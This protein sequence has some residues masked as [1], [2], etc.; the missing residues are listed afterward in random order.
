MNF[1]RMAK[2]VHENQIRHIFEEECFE[3]G[4]AM[5]MFE[6]NMYQLTIMHLLIEG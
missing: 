5:L 6:E 3:V 1:E 2:M 4:C